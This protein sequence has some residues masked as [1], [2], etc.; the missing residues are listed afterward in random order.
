MQVRESYA[1]SEAKDHYSLLGALGQARVVRV[2][3]RRPVG[4]LPMAL[5]EVCATVCVSLCVFL[6][7][8]LYVCVR[9]S[10]LNVSLY[11]FTQVEVWAED[12]WVCRDRCVHG[13]CVAQGRARE[14]CMCKADWIGRNCDVHTM[15][16]WRFLPL[17]SATESNAA[18]ARRGG[19]EGEGM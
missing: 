16:A 17:E 11:P 7:V 6:C 19:A 4:A 15:M 3:R 13:E 2:K 8:S 1:M 10:R 5:L 12:E 14:R 9:V 18:A